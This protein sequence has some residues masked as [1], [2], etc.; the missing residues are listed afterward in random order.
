MTTHLAHL[1]RR[2]DGVVFALWTVALAY[3]L[4]SRQYMDFL[5]PE[6]GLLLALAQ[7]VTMGFMFSALFNR[8]T[9]GK[10]LLG[11]TQSL[12]LITPLVYLAIMPETM[13]G[14]AAFN[15]RFVGSTGISGMADAGYD[16]TIRAPTA[17][18]PTKE[19]R[20][21]AP[22][23]PVPTILEIFE[24]PHDYVGHRVTVVGMILRDDNL[25][26]YY[27]GHDTA[28][29]RFLINCCAADALPLAIA[30]ESTNAAA[31]DKDQWVQ[32]NGIFEIRSAGGQN[33]PFFAEADITAV[34]TPEVPYLF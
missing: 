22:P 18:G 23:K 20:D 34:G 7:F 33:V 19:N 10:G 26:Q 27:G 24:N 9:H 31:F 17:E 5:R 2:F 11:I 16:G 15:T 28:V 6:F 29:Y 21:G 25:K 32:V 30:V 8:H 3:L 1:F 4:V 14:R 13:L 12:V